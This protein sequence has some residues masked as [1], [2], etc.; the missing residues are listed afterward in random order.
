MVE[1]IEGPIYLQRCLAPWEHC[2]KADGCA[3]HPILAKA[4]ADL[5]ELLDG[6]SLRELAADDRV[7]PA[8]H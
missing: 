2:E 7:L 5:L 8:L 3:L 6:T 4:Q 1:A